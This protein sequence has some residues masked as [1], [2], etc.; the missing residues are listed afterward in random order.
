MR[1]SAAPAGSSAAS[2]GSLPGLAEAIDEQS[3]HDSAGEDGNGKLKCLGIVFA[4]DA[5]P[6]PAHMRHV[7]IA[8]R[9]SVRA[10][11]ESRFDLVPAGPQA[12]HEV[13]GLTAASLVQAYLIGQTALHR[14]A[15]Q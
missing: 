12:R 2:A 4:L 9:R 15:D 5:I 11:V 14:L 10:F 1:T 6:N 3:S 7:E 8:G 13:A